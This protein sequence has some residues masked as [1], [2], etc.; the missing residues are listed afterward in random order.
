MGMFLSRMWQVVENEKRSLSS[1]NFEVH[2]RHKKCASSKLKYGSWECWV[3]MPFFSAIASNCQFVA[4]DGMCM[5]I[6]LQEVRIAAAEAGHWK[7]AIA[8]GAREWEE[9]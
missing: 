6:A 9:T 3:S 7:Q 5:A 2:V 8:R 4:G 1:S